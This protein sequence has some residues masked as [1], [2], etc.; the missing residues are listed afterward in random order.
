MLALV[1][2]VSI[3]AQTVPVDVAFK[4][5]E[6]EKPDRP[7][8]GVPVRLVL[9]EMFNWQGLTAGHRFVTSLWPEWAPYAMTGLSFPRR[10][11]HVMIA[12]E[13]EQLIPA[14]N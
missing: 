5:T 7:L 10:S 1:S 4:M 13:L 6:L 11:D 2:S 8:A 3:D 12:A 14:R 9:G